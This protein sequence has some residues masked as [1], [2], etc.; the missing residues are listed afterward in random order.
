MENMLDILMPERI[1]ELGTWRGGLTL[2]LDA[3]A[4]ANDAVVLS[5]DSVDL[6][7]EKTRSLVSIGPTTTF[8]KADAFGKGCFE[9]VQKFINGHCCLVYCDDGNKEKELVKY[10]E[11]IP[12]GSII[13]CHDYTVE[14]RPERIPRMFQPDFVPLLTLEQLKSIVN[15][16]QF[17]LKV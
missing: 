14:V 7:S 17:W 10:C 11:I 2:F 4:R 15:L 9:E 6:M 8:L 12:P 3:W 1:V 16:Q 13:G 5:I